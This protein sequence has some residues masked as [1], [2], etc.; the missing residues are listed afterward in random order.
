M[1]FVGD[2]IHAPNPIEALSD[3]MADYW[4]SVLRGMTHW[5]RAGG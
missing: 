4:K 5:G 2:I 1:A 3:V